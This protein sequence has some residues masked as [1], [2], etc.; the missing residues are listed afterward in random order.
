VNLLPGDKPM[1]A[2]SRVLRSVAEKVSVDT[3]EL[4]KVAMPH[5]DRK[6]VKQPVMTSNYN[7]TF[8]GM[9]KQIRDQ[10]KSRGVERDEAR[11][12]APYVASMVRSAIDDVFSGPQNVMRWI[13]S[14]AKAINETY[15]NRAIEWITPSGFIAIQPYRSGKT[16]KVRTALQE[17]NLLEISEDSPVIKA[18]QRQGFFPNIVH[19][20]DGAHLGMTATAMKAKGREFAGVHDSGWTHASNAEEL[21]GVLADQMIIMHGSDQI[22]RVRSH[23]SAAYPDADIPDPPAYGSLDLERIRDSE[24]FFS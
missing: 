2:Y 9:R 17:V 4:A 22:G 19:S 13:E 23:W 10:L 7:V 5:L 12:I 6:L 21:R 1:D 11:R 16:G 8:V 24:Y 3:N 20:W 14:A 15:P 18:K